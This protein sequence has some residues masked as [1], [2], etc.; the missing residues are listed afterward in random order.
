MIA[1]RCR[2]EGQRLTKVTEDLTTGELLLEQRTR[3]SGSAGLFY[4]PL[5]SFSH[6]GVPAGQEPCPRLSIF[7]HL[8]RSWAHRAQ[9]A[10]PAT[11]GNSSLDDRAVFLLPPP[12]TPASAL[13]T[14]HSQTLTRRC[15]RLASL[16]QP[17]GERTLSTGSAGQARPGGTGQG[18]HLSR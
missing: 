12:P 7:Q 17:P 13:P 4:R 10:T 9:T 11:P 2:P 18:G 3:G 6:G 8:A 16:V 5:P 1:S 14:L 15:L